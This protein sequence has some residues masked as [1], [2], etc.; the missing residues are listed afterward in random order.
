[1]HVACAQWLDQW[2]W[3]ADGAGVLGPTQLHDLMAQSYLAGYEGGRESMQRGRLAAPAAPTN[4]AKAT[5][6]H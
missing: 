5:D 6:G 4:R 1:M 3:P 2:R